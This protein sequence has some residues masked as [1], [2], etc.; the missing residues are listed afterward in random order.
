MFLRNVT[1]LLPDYTVSRSRVAHFMYV[2]SHVN[3]VL[4]S[5]VS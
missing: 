2:E 4:C 3:A 5:F 1:K